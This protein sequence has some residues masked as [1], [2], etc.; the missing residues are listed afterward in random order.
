MKKIWL[1]IL[2]LFLTGCSVNYELDIGRDV[3]LIEN[4][5]LSANTNVD[6]EKI[7]AFDY[8]VPIDYTNDDPSVFEKKFNDIDYYDITKK[9]DNSSL[10]FSYDKYDVNQFNYNMF[11]KSCYQYVTVMNQNNNK[12]LLLSTSRKFL[13]FDKYDNLDDVTVT[14]TSKYKLKETNADEVDGHTY[15]WF[16]TKGNADNKYLYLLLDTTVRELTIWERILEGEFT[17]TFTIFLVVFVVGGIIIFLF[18]KKGDRRNK[19]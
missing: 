3:R 16:I 14:I 13:C 2:V 15:R 19:V 11:A 5:N 1:I 10:S 4:V 17:N 12:E 9:A 7:N 6:V 8:Y 18:K